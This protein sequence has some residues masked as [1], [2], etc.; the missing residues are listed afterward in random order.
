MLERAVSSGLKTRLDFQP[1]TSLRSRG[2]TLE[3]LPGPPYRRAIA[4]W[5]SPN[6]LL[7]SAYVSGPRRA[8]NFGRGDGTE[9]AAA[10]ARPSNP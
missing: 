4:A 10:S 1:L 7:R 6:A 5:M 8:P 2:L 3:L 9:V